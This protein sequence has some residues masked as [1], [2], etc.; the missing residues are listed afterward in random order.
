[1]RIIK[2]W[3][4]QRDLHCRDEVFTYVADK[5][6]GSSYVVV[7]VGGSANPSFDD[8]VDIYVDIKPSKSGKETLIGDI[9]FPDVWSELYDLRPDFV[10]CSH[11][12]EDIR[13]PLFVAKQ[14]GRV[15]RAGFIA[16]PSKH[17]EVSIIESQ[18]W[19]GFCHHRWI[20][21]LLFGPGP[22]DPLGFDRQSV[23]A[24]AAEFRCIA[25]FPL[26]NLFANDKY[27]ESLPW[28]SKQHAGKYSE[29]GFIYEGKLS[30]SVVNL[31]YA[32]DS[33]QELLKLYQN[34]L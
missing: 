18:H 13:D 23:G 25:K 17:T 27:R 20:F 32:G 21:S 3:V 33:C 22:G 34:S 26:S 4:G 14:L 7:D 16:V 15:F 1:M 5:K 19:V 8:I 30:L 29:L 2:H 28:Y 31:D 10:I 12:L 24:P 11:T 9:N 6:K